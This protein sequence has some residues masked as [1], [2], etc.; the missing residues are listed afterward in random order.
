MLGLVVTV[1]C[2]LVRLR[3]ERRGEAGFV[4]AENL[5]VAALGVIALIAIFAGLKAL[6]V[7]VIENIRTRLLNQDLT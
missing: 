7:D 1:E 5:G 3:E 2:W 4:T 6:G